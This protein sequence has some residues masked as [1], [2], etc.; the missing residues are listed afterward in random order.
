MCRLI[1]LPGGNKARVLTSLAFTRDSDFMMKIWGNLFLSLP[2]SKQTRY[3]IKTQGYLI[4][5]L[6]TSSQWFLLSVYCK[7]VTKQLFSLPQFDWPHTPEPPWMT[8]NIL[9]LFVSHGK[10]WII[11]SYV[12]SL[13]GSKELNSVPSFSL[14]PMTCCRY[15]SSLLMAYLWC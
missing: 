13:L 12:F 5:N 10:I 1:H 8:V 7:S 4:C 6:F 14:H 15:L 2:R 3:L 9:I 11:L